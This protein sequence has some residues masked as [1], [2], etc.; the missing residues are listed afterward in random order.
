VALWCRDALCGTFVEPMEEILTDRSARSKKSVTSNASKNSK[1]SRLSRQAQK[2]NMQTLQL[3]IMSHTGQFHGHLHAGSV[4]TQEAT[5]M[6]SS[7]QKESTI[8]SGSGMLQGSMSR[9]LDF[10][11]QA[12]SI[13]SES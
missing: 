5:I 12:G 11:P 3:P 10:L 9:S 6:S 2:I 1:S 13:I 7:L 4:K 8:T